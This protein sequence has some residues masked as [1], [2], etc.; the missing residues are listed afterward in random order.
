M[1]GTLWPL[2]LQGQK[3]LRWYHHEVQ[4]TIGS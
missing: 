3:G 4:G 1:K 2:G